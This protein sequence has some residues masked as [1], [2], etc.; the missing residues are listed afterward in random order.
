MRQT[1]RRAAAA[2]ST[3]RTTDESWRANFDCLRFSPFLLVLT[4]GGM[5]PAGRIRGRE[6]K[7]P[8]SP[9]AHIYALAELEKWRKL[10]RNKTHEKDAFNMFKRYQTALTLSRFFSRYASIR[11]NEVIVRRSGESSQSF[12]P[13]ETEERRAEE[14]RTTSVF[15]Q[16]PK[17]PW[18]GTKRPW[19][20]TKRPWI[21]TKR[22]WIGTGGLRGFRCGSDVNVHVFPTHSN[23]AD[24]R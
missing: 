18:I 19:I 7:E 14:W 8:R 5:L 1:A 13:E 15:Q 23:P 16:R 21:G 10:K 4:P 22:P 9:K 3:K 11:I 20:G 17:H 2:R 12:P 24:C 6:D